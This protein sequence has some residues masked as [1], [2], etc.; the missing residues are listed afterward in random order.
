[1]KCIT[2]FQYKNCTW[3]WN[4]DI[5]IINE[6]LRVYLFMTCFSTTVR[7]NHYTIMNLSFLLYETYASMKET[8]GTYQFL[9]STDSM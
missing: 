7:N 9:K 8:H 1:M 4:N 5:T 2:A 3:Y 6:I